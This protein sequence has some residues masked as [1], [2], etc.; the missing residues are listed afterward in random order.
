MGGALQRNAMKLSA[1]LIALASLAAGLLTPIYTDEIAW[2]MQER[3][4]VDGID[5]GLA[6]TCQS[7]FLAKPPIFMWPVRI[8][9]AQ[10]AQ[11]FPHPISVRLAGIACFGVWLWLLWQIIGKATV[12]RQADRFRLVALSA[13]AL[14]ILPFAMVISRP[15]QPVLLTL[16]ATVLVVITTVGRGSRQASVAALGAVTV[17]AAI[18]LSYHPKAAVYGPL[19]LLAV[20]FCGKSRMPMIRS[21]VF[22][23]ITLMIATAYFYWR[24]RLQCPE[25][26]ILAGNLAK[27]NM[28]SRIFLGEP[29]GHL[30]PEMIRQAWPGRYVEEIAPWLRHMS[31][32]LPAGSVDVW[33]MPWVV[34][35]NIFWF[36]LIGSTIVGLV[37]RLAKE[38]SAAIKDPA[39]LYSGA[40]LATV[41][42]WSALQVSN[43]SYESAFALPLL[44]LAFCLTFAPSL[45]DVSRQGIVDKISEM[46]AW[47]AAL[48]ASVSLALL[49][50]TYVPAMY[51]IGRSPG[52]IQRQPYSIN[53]FG[54]STSRRWVEQAAQRCSIP[55][56]GTAVGVLVDDLS[57]FSFV[58][59][60]ELYYR[61]GFFRLWRGSLDDP[62]SWLLAHNSAGIVHRCEDLPLGLRRHAFSVGPVCCLNREMLARA[63]S[64]PNRLL[65]LEKVN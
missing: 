21:F 15:E 41:T 23:A 43:P 54:Y 60:P 39:F 22:V 49:A 56:D 37:L 63:A 47:L 64:D 65:K 29:I 45:R 5:R 1:L 32:W 46:T 42:G 40:I 8:F 59:T 2:R 4:G 62:A 16:T 57:Y 7:S 52:Y 26:P 33:A 9:S 55:V 44:L 61:T 53:A 12:A 10:V 36:A 3:A 20:P 18:A 14:G 11:A 31:H 30:I 48:A 17:L 6:V 25:D 24:D 19:F 28:L 50:M 51:E 27:E 38:R 58:S 13:M 34:A 35:I